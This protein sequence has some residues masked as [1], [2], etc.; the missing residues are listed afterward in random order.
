MTS[1]L[2]SPA[3][4]FAKLL[5]SQL[6]LVVFATKT[7][8]WS[9][10]AAL[11]E[12][13]EKRGSPWNPWKRRESRR[14]ESR[15]PRGGFGRTRVENRG[16]RRLGDSVKYSLAKVNEQGWTLTRVDQDS[17]W[18][19]HRDLSNSPG[20]SRR[21]RFVCTAFNARDTQPRERN[22]FPPAHC[23]TNFQ[24]G[25]AAAVQPFG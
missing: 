9:P 6:V 1:I 23:Q 20:I 14:R 18:S 7:S 16:A 4:P 11:L 19:S 2:R 22:F 15:C 25:D 21:A 10:G 17:A 3:P 24:W 13:E 8:L 12:R 5:F